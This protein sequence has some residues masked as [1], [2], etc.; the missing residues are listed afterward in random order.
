MTVCLLKTP[1]SEAE[2]PIRIYLVETR[3]LEQKPRAEPRVRRSRTPR[4]HMTNWE[5]RA[6]VGPPD[7]GDPA[8]ADVRVGRAVEDS[9]VRREGEHA[10]NIR[11]RRRPR[12]V[13]R[14]R[15]PEIWCKSIWM[16][17]PVRHGGVGESYIRV[18][19]NN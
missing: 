18:P 14:R 12:G 10:P 4:A 11:M 9:Q 6:R 15:W 1:H 5:R 3:I 16:A 19:C 7:D 8:D 17:V 2:V 13:E